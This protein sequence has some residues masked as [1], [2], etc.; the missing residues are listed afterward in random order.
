MT[1]DETSEGRIRDLLAGFDP[2]AVPAPDLDAVKAAGGARARW[3][4][5]DRTVAIVLMAA[6]VT[7]GAVVVVGHER[8]QPPVPVTSASPTPR[9]TGYTIEL[10]PVLTEAS[11]L[12]GGCPV[13]PS[14]SAA[15]EITACTTDGA[16]QY[17]LG[18]AAVSGRE[19]ER[20][21]AERDQSGDGWSIMLSLDA[22]GTTD[23]AAITTAL[24]QQTPPRDQLAIVSGGLVHSAP[25]VV[26]P[27]LGGAVVIGGFTS[28]AE[29]E[30]FI[31]SATR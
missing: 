12:T 1:S 7:V 3:R 19:I 23:L 15:A 26:A 28:E 4:V 2:G 8:S 9:A 29:A 10:R 27:I 6:A 22:A 13:A 16:T 31:S 17:T 30:S 21:T 5:V 14:A 18:P 20:M 11:A 25:N 24:A